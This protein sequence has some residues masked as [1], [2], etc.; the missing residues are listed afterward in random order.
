MN[1]FMNLVKKSL[2]EEGTRGGVGAF[3]GIGAL[4]GASLLPAL[5]PWTGPWPASLSY[6]PVGSAGGLTRGL[7]QA[8]DLE[9]IAME[10]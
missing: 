2:V 9:A 1:T 7:R 5:N 3:E 6:S 10:I 4:V 8:R